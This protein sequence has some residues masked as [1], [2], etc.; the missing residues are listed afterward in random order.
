M[1]WSDNGI[2]KAE[3][4]FGNTLAE[5]DQVLSMEKSPI[6]EKKWKLLGGSRNA[7]NKKEAFEQFLQRVGMAFIGGVFL[8]GP[9]L[10]MVLHKSRTT[11]LVTTSF[12]VFAIGLVFSVYL[13]KPFDVLSATAAYAAVLVVFTGTS[14]GS[15]NAIGFGYHKSP[16]NTLRVNLSISFGIYVI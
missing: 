5:F 4:K 16:N 9:M 6:D 10:L 3:S 13:E 15:G 14:T 2:M 1:Q 7:A 8:I 11:T 12:C